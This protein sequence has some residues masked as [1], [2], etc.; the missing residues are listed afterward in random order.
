MM[1]NGGWKL[2]HQFLCLQHDHGQTLTLSFLTCNAEIIM[3]T[4]LG[5]CEA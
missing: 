5:F 1:E 4:M 2:G 3:S